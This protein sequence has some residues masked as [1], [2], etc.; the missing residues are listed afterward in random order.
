MGI[1]E[2]RNQGYVREP[3]DD[4]ASAEPQHEHDGAT[5][6]KF[7]RRPEH[8]HQPHQLEAAAD[9][10]LVFG[11]EGADLGLFLHVGADEAGAGK[12]LLGARGDVG[13][14]GLNAFE[15]L[16]N[17]AAK[18]LDHD[19]HRGQRQKSVERE[20]GADRDHEGQRARGVNEGISRIHDGRAKQ[21]ADRV[22]VVGGARHDV[23]GAMALVVRVGEDSRCANKS[24]RRSNSMSREMPITIQRVRNW[25][26][27]L[28][29]A[30]AS[31]TPA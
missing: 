27:P 6:H 11:F 18:S 1:A 29:V 14:H 28:V 22:E 21:H 25:K 13:E 3:V 30:M 16:V 2:I 26:I 10:F 20:P 31:S 19:A 12:V 4:F 17:A 7:E 9:V 5:Q 8:A 15:A 23:A 24:L